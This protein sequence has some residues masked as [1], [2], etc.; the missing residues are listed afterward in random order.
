MALNSVSITW[1]RLSLLKIGLYEGGG[2]LEAP[3]RNASQPL[4]RLRPMPVS[5]QFDQ[6]FLLVH[7]RGKAGRGPP[8]CGVRGEIPR[9]AFDLDAADEDGKASEDVSEPAS[10]EFNAA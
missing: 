9:A 10:A 7:Q 1:R 3:C 6:I 4:E 5:L 2:G 8:H